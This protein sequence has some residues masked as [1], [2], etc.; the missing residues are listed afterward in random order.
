[1]KLKTS[2]K[3]GDALN[4]Y[5]TISFSRKILLHGVNLSNLLL[6]CSP[7]IGYWTRKSE[8]LDHNISE[9][10]HNGRIS[11]TADK[12]GTF[13]GEVHSAE[14]FIVEH[15][16]SFFSSPQRSNW[17]YQRVPVALSRGYSGQ[18]RQ[19]NHSP[20]SSVEVKNGKAISPLPHTPSCRGA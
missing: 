11:R 16:K 8:N 20:P 4:S 6:S 14:Y 10:S 5:M 17:L 2:M 18:E 13:Y 19:A 12:E 7:R 15:G 1:M 9:L 3:V